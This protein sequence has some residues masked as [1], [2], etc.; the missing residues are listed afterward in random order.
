MR[1]CVCVCVCVCRHV[2]EQVSVYVC[3]F[4]GVCVHHTQGGTSFRVRSEL[5]KGAGSEPAWF[6]PS[7]NVL[8]ILTP[9]Y[10]LSHSLSLSHTHTHTHTHT[11]NSYTIVQQRSPFGHGTIILSRWTVY[12]CLCVRRGCLVCFR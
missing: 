8:A 7:S 10:S 12:S 6:L 5:R 3:V 2:T 1:Q 9:S 11:L 4:A